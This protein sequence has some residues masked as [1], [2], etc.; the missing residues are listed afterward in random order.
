MN[1]LK[2]GDKVPENKFID[3]S[4]KS[5]SF[6]DYSG[7]KIILFFYPK[8]D[9]SG[10][11]LEACSIRDRY[12][13]ILDAGYIVF[14]ISADNVSKQEKFANK[15]ALPYPL[16]ADDEK[17]LI[18]AFGVWGPKKFMGKEYDG[19]YRTT[20]IIDENGFIERIINKVKTKDH[21]SQ[22]LES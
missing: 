11:T 3:Q 15:Y 12:K 9:T 18:N 6:L 1:I 2:I 14:G 19:I 13:E 8:A 5:H 22:I 7:S 10:C 20:F 21:S 16:I 17:K 4:S